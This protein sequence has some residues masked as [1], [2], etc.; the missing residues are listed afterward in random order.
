[1]KGDERGQRTQINDADL[2]LMIAKRHAETDR[3]ELADE[4][5]NLQTLGGAAFGI[6]GLIVSTLGFLWKESVAIG[7]AGALVGLLGFG[8]IS[9]AQYLKASG[10]NN[11]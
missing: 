2:K 11:K 9:M 7:V 3:V 10:R 5:A 8:V 4:R 1:M 6:V